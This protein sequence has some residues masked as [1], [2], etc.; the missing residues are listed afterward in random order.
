MIS[1]II[2]IYHVS[3]IMYHPLPPTRPPA[4]PPALPPAPAGL[5]HHKPSTT[6]A[7][8]TRNPVHQKSFITPEG[9]HTK[10]VF[11]PPTFFVRNKSLSRQTPFMPLPFLHQTSFASEALR[12]PR[13]CNPFSPETRTFYARNIWHQTAFTPA[14]PLPH[15]FYT[16]NILLHTLT[17]RSPLHHAPLTPEALCTTSLLHEKPLAQAAL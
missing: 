5:L 2:Y 7:F 12:A 1:Y 17:A 13:F 3:Y 15:S 6:Q 8:Y 4:P 9:C 14:A 11:A 16:R 10:N